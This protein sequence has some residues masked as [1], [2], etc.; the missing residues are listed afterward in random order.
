MTTFLT[1]LS[2]TFGISC[3]LLLSKQQFPIVEKKLKQ[4]SL[5]SLIGIVICILLLF[6]DLRLKGAYTTSIIGLI[7][8]L[9]TIVLFGL[10][11]NR[12]TRILSG[13]LV[14]PLFVVGILSLI[15]KSLSGFYLIILPFQP[16]MAKFE[17]NN[18]HNVEVWPGGFFACRESL[19]I[20][21]SAFGILDRQKDVGNSPCVTGIH[22]I[23]TLEMN[24]T[25][26]EFLIYYDGKNEFEN[27]YKYLVEFKDN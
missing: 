6:H 10:T 14:I 8:L 19:V 7:F 5:Y 4:I 20:T 21:E 22:R 3:F 18:N 26:A 11:K 16:P 12:Q 23:E 17:I 1:L 2:I 24:E 9:S 13:I 25:L 15:F 27:P